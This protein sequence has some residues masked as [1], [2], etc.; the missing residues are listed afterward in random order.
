MLI[1]SRLRNE[2][3]RINDDVRIV[4]VEIRGDKVRLGIEAPK[5]FRVH[6]EEIY[7]KIKQDETEGAQ[8]S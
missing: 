4:I 3:I 1:L 6:R 7:Q 8:F 2:A 5:E